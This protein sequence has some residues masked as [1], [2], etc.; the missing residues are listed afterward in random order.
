MG[1][2]RPAAPVAE[3][4]TVTETQIVEAMSY[5]VRRLCLVVEG[6][7]A[8]ALAALCS[9][10]WRPPSNLAGPVVIV[11][12]GGNVAAGTLASI[13]TAEGAPDSC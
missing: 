12:S 1:S 7:G 5:C 10:A 3:H 9:G 6:G 8:V 13:L 11:L 2:R 4:V